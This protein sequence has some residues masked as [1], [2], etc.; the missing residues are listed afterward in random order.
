MQTLL[1]ILIDLIQGAM[2]EIQ[3]QVMDLYR[4]YGIIYRHYIQL[5]ALVYVKFTV[6]VKD[7]ETCHY[8]EYQ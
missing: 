1:L 7:H 6:I 3:Y 8:F 5:N 2:G 4:V